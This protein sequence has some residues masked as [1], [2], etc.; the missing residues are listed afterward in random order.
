MASEANR[1]HPDGPPTSARDVYSRKA[2]FF[3]KQ[4]GCSARMLIVSMGEDN[5]YFRSANIEEH[6]F[7]YCLRRDIIF[8]P[9]DYNEELFRINEFI[10]TILSGKTAPD[11]HHGHGGGGVVGGNRDIPISTLKGFYAAC[12]H[13]GID[14]RYGDCNVA[15]VL[16]G[17][18]NFA[19]CRNGFT[20][21]KVVELT[22]YYAIKD[23]CAIVFNFPFYQGASIPHV[24]V[25][26]ENDQDR[27]RIV[28]H[29][30][31]LKRFWIDPIVI[32][33]NWEESSDP[34]FIAVCT[35]RKKTQHVYTSD[36]VT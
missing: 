15:D 9:D 7:P 8:H 14:G 1:N 6:E 13:A 25:F 28:S 32:A 18:D 24:K 27:L 17:F 10:N 33:G 31:K 36:L 19:E 30:K 26:F 35:V 29:Y 2:K 11:I 20:G 16:C 5:A 3:C 12:L 4:P 23:E 34:D 21:F 22:Y